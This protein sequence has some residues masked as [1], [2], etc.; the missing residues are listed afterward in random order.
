M[1]AVKCPVCGGVLH[2]EH[3]CND[4]TLLE[5]TEH[6]SRCG[7]W[8]EYMYGNEEWAIGGKNIRQCW[9]DKPD[10]MCRTNKKIK[11]AL[12]MARRNFR[13]RRGIYGGGSRE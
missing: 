6:C 10:T 1:E 4:F 3:Y 7:Y 8:Y 2:K 9:R 11:R 13:K 12:F 5:E